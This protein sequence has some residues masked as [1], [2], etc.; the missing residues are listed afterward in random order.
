MRQFASFDEL[1]QFIRS[2]IE[3]LESAG[4]TDAATPLRDGYAALNGLTDG[5]AMLLE[6][7][8]SARKLDKTMSP[9]LRSQLAELQAVVRKMVYR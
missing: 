5:W 6:G 8:A 3:Q 4:H 1:F 2:L 7:I 9:E